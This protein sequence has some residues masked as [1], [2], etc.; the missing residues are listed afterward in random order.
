MFGDPAGAEALLIPLL[1]RN[2]DDIETLEMLANAAAPQG[3]TKESISYLQRVVEQRGDAG[4]AHLNL[5]LGLLMSGDEESATKAFQKAV[6][7]SEK[8]GFAEQTLFRSFL[9]NREFDKAIALAEK[10]RDA[11]PG[12]Y[13]PL[14]YL[15]LAYMLSGDLD[16]ARLAF[17][18]ALQ[19]APKA[20]GAINN[21]AM[22]ELNSGNEDAAAELLEKALSENAGH[23][24]LTQQ[25]VAL[26]TRR[27][28]IGKAKEILE[29][30]IESNPSAVQPR[31]FLARYYLHGQNPTGVLET[32][33]P[34]VAT[35]GGD[36][37]VI[38]L[39]GRAAMLEG[40][41]S[42][43]TDSFERLVEILPKSP[44]SQ[45]NLAR[46]LLAVGELADARS[47]LNESLQND[48][49]YVPAKVALARIYMLTGD[50]SAANQYLAE[51]KQTAPEHPEIIGL[52][53]WLAYKQNEPQAAIPLFRRALEIAPDSQ[54]LIDL[55]S[56][57]WQAKDWSGA[58]STHE[59]W[60]SE[61]P[62]DVR[63]RTNLGSYYQVLSRDAD[64]ISSY[65]DVLKR[66]GD[67]VPA[68][69]NLAWMLRGKNIQAAYGYAKRAHDLAPDS[70]KI[71]DTLA[72]I[73]LAKGETA[74]ALNL[75]QN[76][77]RKSSGNPQ[78][79]YHYAKA[80]VAN[81]DNEQAIE[82]LE[83]IIASS[84]RAFTE[85][86]EVNKLLKRLKGS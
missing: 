54:L 50:K 40:S 17:G 60:L 1:S 74:Q 42:S 77:L 44:V 72:V 3:K 21:L 45:Y 76:V 43:A 66:N 56:A 51:L 30:A 58:V 37:R 6:E 29:T 36:P 55:A 53:G 34:I 26:Y 67:Y 24:G 2:P 27:G 19:L 52:D 80:L 61:H 64:A 79:K 84:N 68:L 35:H 70:P 78:F 86:Q 10:L 38:E 16:K 12:N 20:L 33:E 73:L 57:Q 69:N 49:N 47:A 5:G 75:S 18:E 8:V 22:L 14:N 85:I 48:P 25:L 71:S 15:G 59:N 4:Y 11:N 62:D 63:V 65:E 13:L 7:L 23:V 81:G 31:I 41:Y 32:I 9:A 39:V 28:D 82:V 83:S 46:S